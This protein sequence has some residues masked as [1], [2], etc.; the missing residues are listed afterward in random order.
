MAYL[1]TLP[2]GELVPVLS[3]AVSA[4][5]IRLISLLVRLST[6]AYNNGLPATDFT[7]KIGGRGA[8]LI[9]V[10]QFF[11][12]ADPEVEKHN[13]TYYEDLFAEEEEAVTP[14]NVLL[15][16]YRNIQLHNPGQ[17]DVEICYNNGMITKASWEVL[18]LAQEKKAKNVIF[19][20]G[21]GMAGSMLSA[22]R[23]LGHKTINGKYQ[24]KLK[25]DEAR[26]FL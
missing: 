13:F 7:L 10:S 12:I 5:L 1:G 19:F 20:V 4:P 11:G 14:A 15:K 22:A 9:D 16:S 25:L 6:S 18:P 26:V 17:Y 21:D 24:T 3:S 8:E 23:L 2:S